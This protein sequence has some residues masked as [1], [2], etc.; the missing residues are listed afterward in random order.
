[1]SSTMYRSHI[2]VRFCGFKQDMQSA[3]CWRNMLWL[4]EWYARLTP[5]YGIRLQNHEDRSASA[6]A[7]ANGIVPPPS[8]GV[9]TAQGFP[10]GTQH[11]LCPSGKRGP[12]RNSW[13]GLGERS[14]G[15]HGV[16]SG[17]L[18]HL[19]RA[20][21]LG[22]R[23][24]SSTQMTKEH[25]AHEVRGSDIRRTLLQLEQRSARSAKAQWQILTIY[26][27]TALSYEDKGRKYCH[28]TCRF[29]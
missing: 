13:P 29:V 5:M 18:A 15:L 4:W 6:S 23:L 19:H 27:G 7:Q 14:L 25:I 21:R 12:W 3:W 28:H 16:V 2:P 10:E 8:L 26:C 22:W 1:M 17:S 24:Q 11:T 20:G 9:F